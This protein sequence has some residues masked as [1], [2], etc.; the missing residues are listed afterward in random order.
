MKE[1]TLIKRE[2][3]HGVCGEETTQPHNLI[4]KYTDIKIHTNI[5]EFAGVLPY[6]YNG[7]R[8]L[9]GSAIGYVEKK[10]RKITTKKTTWL[11]TVGA[12]HSLQGGCELSLDRNSAMQNKPSW[13]MCDADRMEHNR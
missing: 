8:Y 9:E 3:C 6:A 10:P 5:N 13:G 1:I 2:Y 11:L 4:N 12:A 7:I